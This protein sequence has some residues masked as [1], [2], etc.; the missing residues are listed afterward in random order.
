M[1]I[2]FLEPTFFRCYLLHPPCPPHQKKATQIYIRFYPLYRSR[3]LLYFPFV[4]TFPLSLFATL[5]LSVSLL[6]LTKDDLKSIFVRKV[7]RMKWNLQN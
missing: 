4:A 1:K 2:V 6:F 7:R 5:R 3:A